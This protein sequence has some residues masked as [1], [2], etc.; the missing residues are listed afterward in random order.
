MN[1]LDSLQAVL[2]RH[3]TIFEQSLG[4]VHGATAKIHVDDG[5]QLKFFKARPVPYALRE[6]VDKELDHL[7]KEGV[8]QPVTHSDWAAPVVPVVKRDGSVRLCGDYKI[9]VNKI[10]KFDS[11]PLPRIDDLF[12]SLS[13]GQTFTKLDLA[14]AYLQV[15]LDAESKKFTT[16]NTHRGLYQYNRLP[17]GISSAPAIFQRTIENILQNLPQTC[18]YLY[19]I[20]VTGKTE[21]E[22]LQ[23]LENVLTCLENSGLRLKQ[24]KCSFMLPSVDYLGHTIS[25]EGLQPT[26][27]KIR[28]ITDAPTP[29]NV[30]QLRSFLGLVNYYGKFLPQLATTLAPLYSLLQ[31][32]SKWQWTD[33]Q[34]Q[35]F[36]AAKDQLSS[37]KL[38][39]HYNPDREL[40]L[41]CD[42]LPYGIGA[43]LSRISPNM[44][45]KPIAFTSRSLAPAEREYSQLDKEGLS[46]IFG[47]RKFY[48]YLFGRK[49]TIQSDHR[50]LQHIFGETRPV[51]HLASARLQ[52]W[53]LTLGAYDYSICY[54]PGS[55]HSN[56]DMLSRLPLPESPPD[57]PLPG[58]T[59]L[60]LEQLQSSPITAAQIKKWTSQDPVLSRVR[61]N[62]LHGW[63]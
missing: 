11:Y 10:A 24:Q 32:N 40:L 15:P 42:A 8:I 3:P 58:E 63:Q 9:T 22:H 18:V 41:S 47:V 49:F 33:K 29:T 30:A 38:L 46:I 20:P 50:P 37:S 17:F 19:D 14:H 12:A 59:I 34:Q 48:Q 51:P 16:I 60:L 44:E 4:L 21:K 56:A 25:S 45:E 62:V 13:G 1:H 26:K 5:V 7:F 52:R 35:A 28:A 31:R 36:K 61:N 53:A 55:S 23:N 27:E 43:V 2:D 39:V 6:K 57:V 54:K